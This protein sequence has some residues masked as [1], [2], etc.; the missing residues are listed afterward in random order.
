[1]EL[2][3]KSARRLMLNHSA[4]CVLVVAVFVGVDH[5]APVLW[6]ARTTCSTRHAHILSWFTTKDTSPR[7]LTKAPHQGTSPRHLT[8]TP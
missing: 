2:Q 8:K 1:L 4:V 3:L 5:A 6:A 7:H